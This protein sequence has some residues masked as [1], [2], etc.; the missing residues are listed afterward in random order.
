MFDAGSAPL[1]C[2]MLIWYVDYEVVALEI[3]TQ[4]SRLKVEGLRSGTE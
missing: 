4:C 1:L 3:S 2:D